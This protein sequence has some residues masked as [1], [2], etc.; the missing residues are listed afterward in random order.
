MVGDFFCALFGGFELAT[1][2][3]LFGVDSW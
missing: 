1:N 3:S 2:G